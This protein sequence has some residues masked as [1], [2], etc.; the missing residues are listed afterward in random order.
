MFKMYFVKTDKPNVYHRVDEMAR[1]LLDKDVYSDE[2]SLTHKQCDYENAI[3]K[4]NR[5]K[6]FYPSWNEYIGFTPADS[7]TV[8]I[9]KPIDDM[10]HA[11]KLLDIELCFVDELADIFFNENIT[12]DVELTEI[13]GFSP[14]CQEY[15][16]A[17]GRFIN[18]DI[19]PV[20]SIYE[21]AIYNRIEKALGKYGFTTYDKMWFRRPELL[22]PETELLM[23]QDLKENFNINL[24]VARRTDPDTQALLNDPKARFHRPETTGN[25][26]YGS[27]TDTKPVTLIHKLQF[28]QSDYESLS[29]DTPF[30]NH[31]PDVP[32]PHI[33][34]I[35]PDFVAIRI[36]DHIYPVTFDSITVT[37]DTK[38]PSVLCFTCK[39]IKPYHKKNTLVFDINEL[40]EKLHN[41]ELAKNLHFDMYLTMDDTK[42]EIEY[43]FEVTDEYTI[44]TI[45]MDGDTVLYKS[46]DTDIMCG[47]DAAYTDKYCITDWIVTI[48]SSE[49]DGIVLN[50]FHGTKNEVKSLLMDMINHDKSND[51]D[52]FDYATE[53][54]ADIE[55]DGKELNAY[56][57]Y[58]DYHIDYTAIKTCDI[59]EAKLSCDTDNYAE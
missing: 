41:P 30:F 14:Q 12:V 42:E 24:S 50:R 38:H 19:M 36:D 18:L 55:D 6:H 47:L 46:A 3:Q 44:Q 23:K 28:S 51:E 1:I 35:V 40:L 20:T 5:W 27:K 54:I 11:A 53:D 34:A 56:A 15:L 4:A 2:A 33:N 13:R 49:A 52:S 37:A 39:G 59:C 9:H 10:I 45:L 32:V 57:T 17:W 21:S 26:N 16:M 58:S 22:T 48:S 43:D 25:L 7:Q 31:I 8:T 29:E